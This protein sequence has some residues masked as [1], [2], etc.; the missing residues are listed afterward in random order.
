MRADTAQALARP[1]TEPIIRDGSA[2]A[3]ARGPCLDGA[4]LR[5]DAAQVRA[6]HVPAGPC[7]CGR[8]VLEPR[9]R[10]IG[11]A[12]DRASAAVAASAASLG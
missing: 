8:A 3:E 5:V 9:A 7:R 2:T 10:R 6:G 1:V 4:R 12:P 11:A